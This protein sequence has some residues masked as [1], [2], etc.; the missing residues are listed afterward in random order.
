[1]ELDEEKFEEL[2]QNNSLFEDIKLE[3]KEVDGRLV[4]E[5]DSKYIELF[6]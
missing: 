6:K 4:L 2:R 3:A 1:L 5:I